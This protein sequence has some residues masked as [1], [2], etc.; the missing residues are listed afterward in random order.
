M[1]PHGYPQAPLH[2]AGIA[3]SNFVKRK[4]DLQ[5][6][7]NVLKTVLVA[8]KD[9]FQEWFVEGLSIRKYAE[10]Q[11]AQWT[12]D[13]FSLPNKGFL[14]GLNAGK[15]SVYSF[16]RRCESQKAHQCWFSIRTIGEAVGMNEHTVRKHIWQLKKYE[17][18]A[19][20]RMW[21][22]TGGSWKAPHDRL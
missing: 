18:A 1:C 11:Q 4:E 5:F 12:R 22:S 9:Y 8:Y 15:L 13:F 17:L 2:F 10:A 16:P 14:L 6:L 20:R 21:R 3:G 19:E 7:D